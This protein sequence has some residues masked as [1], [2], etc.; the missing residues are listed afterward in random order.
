MSNYSDSARFIAIRLY[1]MLLPWYRAV[2]DS[3]GDT[4]QIV[5]ALRCLFL[6][7]HASSE[8]AAMLWLYRAIEIVIDRFQT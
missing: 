1:G 5:E 8:A 3:E 7:V 4:T 2:I 6:A